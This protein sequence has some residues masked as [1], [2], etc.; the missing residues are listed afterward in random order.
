[1]K[2]LIALSSLYSGGA[3][4]V[5]CT[6]AD[7]W[8][9]RGDEV[10]MLA[11]FSEGGSC[12]YK[13]SEQ[14]RVVYLA[15]LTRSRKKSLLNRV[16]RLAAYRRLLIE[17]R[18]DVIVSFLPG[19]NVASVAAS[20]GLGIPVIACERTDPLAW[21]MPSSAISLY[22]LAYRHADMLTVQTQAVAKKIPAMFPRLKRLEVVP[23]PIPAALQS[24]APRVAPV[25][26]RKRLIAMGRL[27]EEKQFDLL[28]D[29]FGLIAGAWPEWDLVIFGEGNLQDALARQVST[30]GLAHRI[31]LAGPTDTPWQEMACSDV[32]VMTSR[33]EGFP[34][35]LL[36]AMALGLPCA[37]FD[38]TSGPREI[39]R[40]GEDAMLVPL[41][42]RPALAEALGKLM[43]NARLREKLGRS[44]R[45]SVLDR[46]SLA[47][48]IACW[49]R[50]F[51]EVGAIRNPVLPARNMHEEMHA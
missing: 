38:C 44:A 13:L 25:R 18:P 33:I 29:V 6:L 37:V 35:A 21:S 41:N 23:N 3:E 30:S 27:S 24:F 9:A 48:V 2:I 40:D 47:A 14:V 36:E 8:A 26:A 49:D 7:A 16:Q 4:R 15:N 17:E 19:V 46:F 12:F 22:R 42:D 28:I 31:T 11:T 45:R 32:F 39:T 5:A 20:R 43:G 34:N 51:R 1:M 50:L 10:I